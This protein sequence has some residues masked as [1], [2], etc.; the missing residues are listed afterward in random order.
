[1]SLS[2]VYKFNSVD[3]V[4]RFIFGGNAII[5][6]ESSKTGRRFTFKVKIAKKDD[7]KSPYFVSLLTGSNNEESYTYMGTIFNNDEIFSFKLTKKSKITE[8]SFSYK[9]F[10]IFLKLLMN[11]KL[12]NDMNIYHSGACG[13]CGRTLTTPDSLITGLGPECRGYSIN[14]SNTEVRKQKLNRL[15]LCY[16]K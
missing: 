7:I 1:M 8:D 15:N 5:T 2:N 3:D 12:H 16:S 13:R 9:A 6:L 4:K 10:D 11:N 14:K